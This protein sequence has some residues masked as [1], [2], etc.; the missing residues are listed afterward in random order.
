VFRDRR[1]RARR[2]DRSGGAE[3]EARAQQ[4]RELLAKGEVFHDDGRARQE[5]RE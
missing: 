2:R 5:A 4:N 3:V 1:R